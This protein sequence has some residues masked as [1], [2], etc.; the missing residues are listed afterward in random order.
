MFVRPQHLARGSSAT[1]RGR[2][3]SFVSGRRENGKGLRGKI[4]NVIAFRHL[5]L[6]EGVS[7]KT[8]RS[9]AWAPADKMTMHTMPFW[10]SG[11]HDEYLC[12]NE[13]VRCFDLC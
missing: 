8:F 12:K 4:G 7:L 3:D 11:I 5:G 6:L 10:Q 1:L 9:C 13:Q 2:G